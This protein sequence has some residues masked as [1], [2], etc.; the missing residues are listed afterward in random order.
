VL[1]RRVTNRERCYGP[2]PLARLET[3]G[4]GNLYIG[5]TFDNI[6]YR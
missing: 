4:K 5:P 3:V 6:A 2:V 1:A